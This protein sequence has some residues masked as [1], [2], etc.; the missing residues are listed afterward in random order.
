MCAIAVW[1]ATCTIRTTVPRMPC[2]VSNFNTMLF[3]LTYGIIT[4]KLC[5]TIIYMVNL[6]STIAKSLSIHHSLLK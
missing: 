6:K 5:A 1:T 3:Y 4:S 2:A